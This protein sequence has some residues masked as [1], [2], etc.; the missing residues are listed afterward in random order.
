MLEPI[1]RLAFS[2][3]DD[4]FLLVVQIY[5]LELSCRLLSVAGN[6][7]VT[8][9]AGAKNYY[10]INNGPDRR[11]NPGSYLGGYLGGNVASEGTSRTPSDGGSVL[12]LFQ[13]CRPTTVTRFIVPVVVNAIDRQS[14]Q[15]PPSNVF[16]KRNEIM[17]PTLA[18]HD[19]AP[20][21]VA[22][23]WVIDV[24]ATLNQLG[25]DLIF[26]GAGIP[27]PNAAPFLPDGDFHLQ[28][29]P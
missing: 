9:G 5:D 27:V 1:N 28:N 26:L 16:Y 21:V 25:P 24:L 17:P 10:A 29:L 12:R 13:A 8:T 20:T 23:P 14:W 19:T 22:I 18:N 7:N 3:N 15:R 2:Q 6:C 4:P 11:P